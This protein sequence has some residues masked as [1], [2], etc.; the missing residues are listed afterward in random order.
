MLSAVAGT[1]RDAS[2][3]WDPL[4]GARGRSRS[5]IDP[6]PLVPR[7]DDVGWL[8][9]VDQYY[10]GS[11][12]SIAHAN[13]R[14]IL[15]ATI[16][17]LLDNPDRKF[18]E[19]EQAFFQRWWAVQTPDKQA[20]VQTLVAEGR[21]EFIN[22]GWSMHDEA[23]PTFVDM[24]DNTALGQ[25]LI[26][27]SFAVVPKT[28]WQIDP[29]GH[30][31]FQG[32][33]LS[34]PLS[35]VNGVYVARMD[36][37]DIAARKA[38]KGTEMFWAPSPS[39]PLQG[40]VLGF[41]PF[42]YYAPGGFNF[43]GDDS[44]EPVMDQ[45]GLEDNNVADVVARFN[46]L[47]TDQLTFTA[48]NDVMIMMAT[49]FSGENAFT[50]FRNIDSLIRAVNANGTFH[51]LYST[52]SIYTA[53]KVAN[54]PLPLRTEDVM[55]YADGPHAFWSGYFTSRAALKG[56]IRDS[57]T[58]YQ[59]AKQLQFVTGGCPKGPDDQA[60]NPLYLLERAMGV[61]QHHDA[62]SG[63]AKQA[64]T[65]DYARRLAGGRLA[66]D[67]LF[68]SAFAQLTGY[69]TAPFLACDLANV[70][71]CPALEAG[72]ATVLVLYNEDSTAKA[73]IPVHVPVGLPTGITKY[74]VY[75]ATGA[76]LPAQMLPLSAT[77][78]HLRTEYYSYAGSNPVQWLAFN[79]GPVPAMG[80]TVIFLQPLGGVRAAK[81]TSTVVS[82]LSAPTEGLSSLRGAPVDD[83]VLTNG[84]VSLSFDGTTGF[85]TNYGN[86]ASGISVAM[87]S[88]LLWWNSSAGDS[89]DDKSGDNDQ[90]SG[91]Y[92]F[93]PNGTTPFDVATG[94]VISTTFVSSGPVV[95]EARQVFA[96]WASQTLR[97][98]AGSSVVEVEF[99]IGPIPWADGL[100]KEI[101]S[102][103]GSADFSS[104]AGVWYSDS[105]GRDTVT[106]VRNHRT[107]WNY[108]VVEPIAGNYVPT[109]L[110]TSLRSPAQAGT[111]LSIVTD[112]TQ[113]SS[114]IIDGHLDLMVHRRLQADD[115]RGVGE[116]LNETGLDGNGLI[117]RGVHRL[118]IDT[119]ATAGATVRAMA[120]NSLFKP[121]LRVA[122]N[123]LSPATWLAA[124][125]G[126][127]SALRAS[128]A[129]NLQIV[130]A[131][132]LSPTSV[133][134]RL[135]HAFG[136][137]EDAQLSSPAS[138]DLATLFAP[139]IILDAC[140]E[141]TLPG[142]I[143]LTAAPVTTFTSTD[144]EVVTLPIIPP[145]PAGP[146]LTVTLAAMQIRTFSCAVQY[147]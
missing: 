92:L 38:Y 119:A 27:N 138:A 3:P 32:S 60:T 26:Y 136:V 115:N 15:D 124:Y 91:A 129:P 57:S 65:D 23:C 81:V 107:S 69:T 112:R 49:D 134:L 28:T 25:R 24:L 21:L 75:D 8:K 45:E 117:V 78:S 84:I 114:S 140:T 135:A 62:V 70:T 73:N 20:Q 5:L 17:A 146:G 83:T 86:A 118:S 19:V 93:R 41:L 143:P 46:A 50:W 33:M 111:T 109:N 53:A 42:W 29:F 13:V 88:T 126:T 87:T 101:I 11:K 37:Q 39:Q 116:P 127:F 94:G 16:A 35:G 68:T 99:T 71:I 147:S 74:A 96:P 47:I 90:A 144:G 122:A 10:Y 89:R 36:Y 142:T 97:L 34:S 30:S 48:G 132:S 4:G 100:G 64:V 58:V 123:A 51:A 128:L 44:T 108:T 145:A 113:A 82:E 2:A 139:R 66:A 9:T 110:F 54:T 103:Y 22:G 106:R 55:P 40:G 133:L 85:L 130:T 67:T 1:A 102:R 6:T 59:A 12:N 95:W 43:G 131:Q 120:A 63:T 7:S 72:T 77:D 105:N 141:M 56:Y 104:S 61:T 80:F 31:A 125:N 79:S 18:I 14:A 121:Q 98:W 52:P 76:A 137:G